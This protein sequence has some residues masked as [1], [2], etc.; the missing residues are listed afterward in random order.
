MLHTTIARIDEADVPR[1]RDWLAS[2]ADRREELRES[3][4]TQGTRHEQFFLLRTRRTPI[5]VLISELENVEEGTKA[6]LASELPID[7]EFK[8]L[9]Q[10]ISPEEAEAEL[11]YD[12][13]Q[14]LDDSS[15]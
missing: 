4:R 14:Y 13:S 10:E 2:L 15:S 8:S 9:Y 11:L 7:V 3:Y 6:F 12:S 1:L 5:L